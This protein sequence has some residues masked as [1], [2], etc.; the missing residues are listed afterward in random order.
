MR[1]FGNSDSSQD[2]APALH[3]SLTKFQGNMDVLTQFA[4]EIVQPFE[5]AGL[6]LFARRFRCATSG[7]AYVRHIFSGAGVSNPE[8]EEIARVKLA[9]LDTGFLGN[10]YSEDSIVVEYDADHFELLDPQR[11]KRY[12]DPVL[13]RVAKASPKQS[14]YALS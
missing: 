3:V 5:G 10:A 7:I 2:L 9:N 12:I 1:R 11:L 8:V 4:E 14:R 13:H 6:D